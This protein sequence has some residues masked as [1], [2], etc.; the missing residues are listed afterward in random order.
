M[1][2][3]DGFFK[4]CGV[5][6]LVRQVRILEIR[7]NTEEDVGILVAQIADLQFFHFRADRP[8]IRQQ[9]RHN[10]QRT[11]RVGN[12]RAFKIHLWQCGGGKQMGEDVIQSR[13]GD[14]A[15]GQSN[16]EGQDNPQPRREFLEDK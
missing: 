13:H 16:Q 14:L 10:H 5:R 6:V 1:D 2:F 8:G 11:K 9:D 3:L 15:D 12:P 7:K 4:E